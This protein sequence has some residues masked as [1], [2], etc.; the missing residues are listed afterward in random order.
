LSPSLLTDFL[1]IK[2][3]MKEL[4]IM[5]FWAE[6]LQEMFGHVLSISSIA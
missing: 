3:S 2:H 5:T 6:R 1:L 4:E